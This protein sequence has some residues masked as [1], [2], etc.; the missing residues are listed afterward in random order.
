MVQTFGK[1]NFD[2]RLEGG[3]PAVPFQSEIVVIYAHLLIIKE[4]LVEEYCTVWGGILPFQY[5]DTL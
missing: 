5:F 4:E 2:N 1:Q 3:A